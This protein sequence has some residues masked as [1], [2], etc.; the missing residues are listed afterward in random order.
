MRLREAAIARLEQELEEATRAAA[1][2]RAM[3]AQALERRAKARAAGLYKRTL[4]FDICI[5][6]FCR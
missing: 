3:H 6:E 2:L 1:A 5:P 4:I